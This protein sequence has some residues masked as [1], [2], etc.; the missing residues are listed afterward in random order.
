[1]H[2][3]AL[4]VRPPRVERTEAKPLSLAQVRTLL[5]SVSGDRLQPLY[6]VAIGFGLRQGELLLRWSDID[7]DAGRPA[8]R[9]ARNAR[10]GELAEPKT[11]RSRRTLRLGVELTATLRDHR[12][13]PSELTRSS[14]GRSNDPRRWYGGWY[15]TQSETPG[16][17]GRGV[18][19]RSD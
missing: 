19:S 4:A 3:V 17:N 16:P 8:V 6:R 9:Y 2:N 7:L 12:R 13:Q 1:M 10:T 5:A 15:G 11:D 18:F 14:V